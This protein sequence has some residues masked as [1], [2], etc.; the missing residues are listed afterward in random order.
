MFILPSPSIRESTTPFRCREISPTPQWG[1]PF[2]FKLEER[3]TR[4]AFQCS[5]TRKGNYNVDTSQKDCQI[6]E[7]TEENSATPT[8]QFETV[9]NNGASRIS[10]LHTHARNRSVPFKITER[11]KSAACCGRQKPKREHSSRINTNRDAQ[12]WEF[13]MCHVVFPG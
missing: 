13:I 7:S 9:R 6:G 11:F 5:H 10:G 4:K 12:N 2:H 3:R 1:I 8:G